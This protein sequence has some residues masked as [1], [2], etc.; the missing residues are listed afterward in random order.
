MNLFIRSLI[1][2]L[3]VCVLSPAA[4]QA[5]HQVLK[6][7]AAKYN[8]TFDQ[9]VTNYAKEIADW[10]AHMAK[11]DED[12]K[13][14]VPK[15][16]AYAPFPAPTAPAEISQSV[17]ATGKPN[18]TIVNDDPT[19]DAILAGKK[20]ILMQRVAAA[21]QA[22]VAAIAPQGKQAMNNYREGDIRKSDAG[23]RS[24]LVES[25]RRGIL[26][27]LG[28]GQKSPQTIEDEVNAARAAADT[29]FLS[30]QETRRHKLDSIDRE[31]AKMMSDIDDLTPANVDTFVIA[32]LPN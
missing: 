7:A 25:Q 4:A 31:V 23:V 22:A 5:P 10:R 2:A 28:I 6:S 21:A 24:R 14:N 13:N 3:V 18:Y 16:K 8:G 17:D 19:P 1:T 26:P 12:K 9:A 30:D 11:V 29:Q 20:A 15:D 32:P 27:M